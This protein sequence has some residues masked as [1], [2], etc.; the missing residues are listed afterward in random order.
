MQPVVL[1]YTRRISMYP[2]A[3]LICTIPGT[4]FRVSRFL[5]P[6]YFPND[7]QL[8]IAT[9]FYNFNGFLDTVI[10]G[11]TPEV[12]FNSIFQLFIQSC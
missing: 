12:N 11:T 2:L 4:V 7:W 5:N 10:F 6:E 8:S 9:A 1:N 3:L